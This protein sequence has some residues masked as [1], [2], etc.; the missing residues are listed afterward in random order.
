M[1][2]DAVADS[3][4]TP[5]EGGGLD[6][7][8]LGARPTER[9]PLRQ[10]VQLSVYWLGIQAIWG[11]VGVFTQERI[12]ELVE[13]GQGGTYLALTGWIILPIVL[14]VQ[15]TVGM[16]SDYTISRWGRRKPYIVIGSILDVLFLV[17]LATSQTYLSVLAFLGLLQF[18]SNFAQG[19]F[20]GYVPDLVPAPQ[21]GLAS[22]LIGAMQ[23]IGFVIGNGIIAFS[24]T[25]GEYVLPLIF[26][27]LI[28]LATAIGTVVWVREGTGAKPRNGKSWVAIGRSAWGLD[29]LRERSF[30]FLVVSRL[31]FIAGINVLLG[32]YVLFV[33]RV[34]GFGDSEKALWLPVI[35]V[36]VELFTATA[37]IPSGILSNRFGRK[38]MIYLA[39]AIGSIGLLISGL[40]PGPEVLLVGA[41]LIGMGSGTFL[42]VDWALMTDIIPKA[43]SGRF[44]GISNLAVGLAGPV[45]ALLAGPI[46][47]IVGGGAAQ[48][49]DGPRAAFLAGIVFFVLAA[50]FLRPV[51]PRPREALA[52]AQ[53]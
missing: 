1:A 53:A 36:V 30:V 44:M 51:D 16:I 18:S 27:G 49:G 3:P 8:D 24:Y 52:A 28:E 2:I 33:T 46:I 15:P 11:G 32:F 7:D 26:L 29:I 39:A 42:A 25:T 21:V 41:I 37:T 13:P 38:P 19:P 34:F 35:G 5:I 45:A 31:A 12:P 20:Q 10:L 22:A 47:D 17:G 48:T 50:V 6:S 9:L 43:S 4:A 40:A 23:T 14:V